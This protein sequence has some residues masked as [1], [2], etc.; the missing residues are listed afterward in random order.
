MRT[1]KL[2]NTILDRNY[3]NNSN[4]F[5]TA[6]EDGIERAFADH[7]KRRTKKPTKTDGDEILYIGKDIA[8]EFK[9]EDVPLDKKQDWAWYVVDRVSS[10]DGG[11]PLHNPPESQ[12]LHALD[13][14]HRAEPKRII[15]VYGHTGH[16]KT[17]FLRHFF[18]R[19][20]HTADSPDS[21]RT[22]VIRL[23]LALCI[24]GESLESDFDNR[25][26]RI[27]RTFIPWLH[28]DEMLK[29]ILRNEWEDDH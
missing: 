7:A 2:S 8:K 10:E 16:G 15:V 13:T 5:W 3:G 24:F 6:F 4:P 23:S 22:V 12:F 17:T 19:W 20:Y 27:L 28:S 11:T 25:F 26:H 21:G 29:D 9:L 18:R 14:E 1:R